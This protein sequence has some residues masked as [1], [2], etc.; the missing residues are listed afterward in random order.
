MRTPRLLRRL[1]VAF[2]AVATLTILQPARAGN[3]FDLLDIIESSSTVL[4]ATFNLVPLVVINTGPDQWTI[5]LPGFQPSLG[6][7]AWTEPDNPL[8]VNRL[9]MDATGHQIF[10]VS[11]TVALPGDMITADG[12][13]L[14][15]AVGLITTYH[16]REPSTVPESGSTLVFLSLACLLALRLKTQTA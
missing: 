7:A 3:A 8:L 10:V 14:I 9:T 15:T 13:S 4:S 11:D 6:P 1:S 16:D 2:A 5:T 12:L